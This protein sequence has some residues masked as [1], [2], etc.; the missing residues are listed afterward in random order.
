MNPSVTPSANSVAEVLQSREK[1]SKGGLMRR[2]SRR[3]KK[4]APRRQSSVILTGRDGTIGPVIL[5]RRSDSNNTA[6]AE[7]VFYSDSADAFT[8]ERDE[9]NALGLMN[10]S[11]RKVSLTSNPCSKTGSWSP[12]G[13]YA[14]PVI[15]LALVKGTSIF[16]VSK[17][18]KYKKIFLVLD[19]EAA[20]ITWDKSHPSKSIYI[21]DIKE[22]R[23]G[24]DIRQY[25]LDHEVTESEEARFFSIFY[26]VADKSKSKV[27]HL[28]SEDEET[29]DNWVN[30]LDSISKH[31]QDLMTSLMSFNEK[32]I[33]AYWASEMTKQFEGRPHSIDDEE[34]EFSGVE[35]VCHNLHIH[36]SP[37]QL[38]SKFTLAD[39]TKTGCLTYGEF[40]LFVREMKCREDICA[41]YR[42]AATTDVETGMTWPEFVTFLRETQGEDVE[43]DPR[44]WEATFIRFARGA[45]PSDGESRDGET[46]LPPMTEQ[47]F[48]AYLTSAYNLP[49]TREPAGC[50]LDRP[51]HEYFISSSHN[52][53][54]LGRQVADLSSVEGY[55]T[56]LAKG[57]RSIEIDCWDG[58]DGQPQVLHGY[59][60]TNA[61]SFREV[62]NI[63][64]KYAFVA[65][66]FPLL[67]SL[68]VHCNNEQQV[69]MS[70]IMKEI[71][72]NRLIIAPLDS[73]SDKLPSPSQLKHRVLIKVKAAAL[74]VDEPQKGRTPSS[75]GRRRGNNLTSPYAKPAAAD[76]EA[77]PAMY[78]SNSPLLN[79]REPSRLRVGKRYNT[80]TESEVQETVSSNTSDNDSG[81]EGTPNKKTSKVVAALGDLGVYFTGVKFNGFAALDGKV[82]FHI[83]TLV[84][85][86]CSMRQN[87]VENR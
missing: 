16:K 10:G 44:G 63:V 17:K 71:F 8:D 1:D 38:Q 41:V 27:M 5:R 15:P 40:Q 29:F 25:R 34:I 14:G 84:T 52:T 48:A 39:A 49:L 12:V 72:G 86:P 7:T 43:D 69:I 3:A 4:L 76:D 59:A 42:G 28:I 73:S 33:R 30:A 37:E 79:P 74:S 21:D 45:S 51:L 77:V 26:A 6:P 78:V 20:K 62:I 54:L 70:D 18:R 68:E 13:A 53:Y 47:A 61:I 22:I 82:P 24:S 32:A 58:P 75:T 50:S 67:V 55:I 2:L 46:S 57:C 35:R 65:S 83:L 56:A 64:H 11:L 66:P 36:I 81:S 19:L 85:G 87:R 31:R 80:I 9:Y 60:M 23:V